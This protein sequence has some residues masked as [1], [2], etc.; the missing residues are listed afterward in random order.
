ML[1]EYP[2]DITEVGVVRLSEVGGDKL[3]NPPPVLDGAAMDAI[4]VPPNS[5]HVSGHLQRCVCG[6]ADVCPKVNSG[7]VWSD[8]KAHLDM[9]III[10]VGVAM[11]PHPQ[12]GFPCCAACIISEP[13]L[14]GNTRTSSSLQR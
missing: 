11:Q 5:S 6:K 3:L 1:G 10:N 2:R 13:L 12:N 14:P 8:G 4:S 9:N 7:H